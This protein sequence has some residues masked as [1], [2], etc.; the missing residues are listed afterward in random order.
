MLF[1]ACL[2]IPFLFHNALL[3]VLSFCIHFFSTYWASCGSFADAARLVSGSLG[4]NSGHL[5]DYHTGVVVPQRVSASFSAQLFY[6]G[7][8][9]MPV[10][11]CWTCKE[12]QTQPVFRIAGLRSN[13][14]GWRRASVIIYLPRDKP[15]QTMCFAMT[16]GRGT[17]Y[18]RL[19]WFGMG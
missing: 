19:P 1:L 12:S 13:W 14:H 9:F 10:W 11:T 8:V 5:M 7:L 3:F 17:G 16:C 15:R 4:L 2:L 6:A 18:L